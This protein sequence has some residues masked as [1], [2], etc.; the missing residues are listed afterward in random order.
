MGTT[1]S[2]NALAPSQLARSQPRELDLS[3]AGHECIGH[4]VISPGQNDFEPIAPVIPPVE[5][6]LAREKYR[7]SVLEVHGDVTGKEMRRFFRMQPLQDD[8][9]EL[10]LREIRAALLCRRHV[11]AR[12]C[13][14]IDHKNKE[15]EEDWHD[16]NYDWP[17]PDYIY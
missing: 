2:G 1:Y 10:A 5:R 12:D 16:K 3:A 6:T 13:D 7:R 9:L 11:L 14:H 17:E 4:H 15:C 8:F